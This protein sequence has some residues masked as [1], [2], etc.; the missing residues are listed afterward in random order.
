MVYEKY[1]NKTKGAEEPPILEKM[2]NYELSVNEGG[3]KDVY[4]ELK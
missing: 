3:G 1:M 2:L 4:M